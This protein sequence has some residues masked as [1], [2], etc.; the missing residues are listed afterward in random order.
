MRKNVVSIVKRSV[1]TVL[2][3]MMMVANTTV[4]QAAPVS[5]TVVMENY[6]GAR[7]T[8]VTMK[9]YAADMETAKMIHD[10]LMEGKGIDFKFKSG[11]SVKRAE[12]MMIKLQKKVREINGCGV[13]FYPGRCYTWKEN[14]VVRARIYQNDAEDYVY[15][16]KFVEKM[17]NQ[18]REVIEAYYHGRVSDGEDVGSIVDFLKSDE[19][20]AYYAVFLE[21]DFKDLSEAQKVLAISNSHYFSAYPYNNRSITLGKNESDCLRVIGSDGITTYMHHTMIDTNMDYKV[22]LKALYKGKA[23]GVCSDFASI[24]C[25]IWD[26]LGL[27]CYVNSS[28]TLNHAWSVV[29]A[30][31]GEGKELWIPFDYRIG[32]AVGE[33]RINSYYV[34]WDMYVGEIKGAPKKMNYSAKELTI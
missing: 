21:K 24:E 32:Y 11:I 2:G 10:T 27:K 18:L 31:N 6:K 23:A 8:S 17:Y 29:V 16:T 28:N 25:D 14:G 12:K 20:L 13:S 26:M 5:D 30:K 15:G 19:E 3:I 7:N 4:I 9:I 1:L 22:S 33:N 34:L